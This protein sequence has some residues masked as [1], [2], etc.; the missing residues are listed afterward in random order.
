MWDLEGLKVEGKYMG[1]IAVAGRVE[2]SRVKYGGEVEHT[3]VLDA[4]INVYGAERDRVLLENKYV[5]RV[6]AN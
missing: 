6:Y 2:S 5:E 4:P 3:V 1:D